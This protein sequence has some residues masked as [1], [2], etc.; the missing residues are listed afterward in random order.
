MD[1]GVQSDF[2]EEEDEELT[3]QAFHT[4][5]NIARPKLLTTGPF[6]FAE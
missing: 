1:C 5:K 3:R 6:I 2:L 4:E